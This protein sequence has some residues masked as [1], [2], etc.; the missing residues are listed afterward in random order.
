MEEWFSGSIVQLQS[1]GPPMTVVETKSA[2][3]MVR[4][5]WYWRGEYHTG[6]LDADG[7]CLSEASDEWD[8]MEPAEMDS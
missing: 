2:E 4:C 7:L 6:W 3:N 1:G 8:E 5:A